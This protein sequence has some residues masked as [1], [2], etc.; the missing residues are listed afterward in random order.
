MIR[1]EGLT[2]ESLVGG[3]RAPTKE[4]DGKLVA[5]PSAPPPAVAKP[6]ALEYSRRADVHQSLDN[7]RAADIRATD[8]LPAEKLAMV[9]QQRQAAAPAAKNAAPAKPGAGPQTGKDKAIEEL[10]VALAEADIAAPINQLNVPI[11]EKVTSEDEKGREAAVVNSE[12]GSTGAFM[13]IG[14][15]GGGFSLSDSQKRIIELR[16]SRHVYLRQLEEQKKNTGQ[17]GDIDNESLALEQK[18]KEVDGTL[19]LARQS[20]NEKT[21]IAQAAKAVAMD[22]N[23]KLAEVEDDYNN[24]TTA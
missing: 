21:H 1:K 5:T 22:L 4:Y 19:E 17:S 18:I 13:A 16:R 15:G 10:P 11:E 2:T 9:Q 8:G 14:G 24:T 23:V 3:G 12:T 6:E 20:N 7:T